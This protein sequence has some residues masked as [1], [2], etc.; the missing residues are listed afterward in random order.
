MS[1]ESPTATLFGKQVSELQSDVVVKG[2]E[3]SGTLHNVTGYTDFSSSVSEQSG[4][5]LALKIPSKGEDET[6]VEVVG[7]TKGPV[8]LDAD[9]N[10][11]LLIASTSQSVKVVSKKDEETSEKTYSLTN[12]TLES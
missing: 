7:G 5:Y 10:I 9:R 2:T 6:T 3:I 8:K 4:H 1:P 12:I 11:V